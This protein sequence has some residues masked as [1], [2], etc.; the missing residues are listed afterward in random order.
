MSL[1]AL[2]GGLIVS[3]Q[4][5][6]GSALAA[7]EIVAAL[8]ACALANGAVGV[9]LEGTERIGTVRARTA[10]PIIGIVKRTVPG[11]EPY[12]T[13]SLAE[14]EAAVG[15][16]ASIVAADATARARPDGSTFADAVRAIHRRGALAMADCATFEDAAAASAAGADIVAT[17]LCGYT[18]PTRGASLPAFDLVSAMKPLGKFTVC[19]G[20]IASPELAGR[21]FAAGADAIVVG[22]ALTD[23]DA[24][25][26][27]FA[28]ASPRMLER[29]AKEDA[30]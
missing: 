13:A 11:F 2:R 26:R 28:A 8:A 29:V 19:E 24:A 4:P 9:R 20:G 15:A 10:A 1:S 16:G 6:A 27:R 3:I 25:V 21:A 22:T 7:P 5:S 30:R 23:L 17:T 14:V 12:I 18:L